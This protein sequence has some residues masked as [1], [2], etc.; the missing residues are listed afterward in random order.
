M[1]DENSKAFATE[2]LRGEL[3]E[4]SEEVRNAYLKH[5]AK[6]IHDFVDIMSDAYLSWKKLDSEISKTEEQA[7][8]SAL[9]FGTINLHTISMKLLIN[10]FFIPAGNTQRQALESAAMALL[11][12]KPSLGF[13]KRYMHEKYSSNKAVR[14]VVKHH[15]KLGLNREALKT[16]ENRRTFYDKFSHPTYMTLAASIGMARPGRID[17]GAAF[18]EAKLPFYSNEINSKV[19]FAKIISNIIDGVRNNLGDEL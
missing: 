17:F 6:E 11:C 13:L 15:K 8:I 1:T 3:L 12:S 19:N 18:D 7:Y 9:L 2:M 4:G 10:G 14:D 5:F 16:L